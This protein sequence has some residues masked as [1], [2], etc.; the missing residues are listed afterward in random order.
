MRMGK[1]SIRDSMLCK[2]KYPHPL[3][4]KKPPENVDSVYN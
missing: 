1:D 4:D 2:Q 3:G